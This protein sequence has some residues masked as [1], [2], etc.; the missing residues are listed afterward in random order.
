M[1]DNFISG[2]VRISDQEFKLISDL[3]YEMAG[4]RLTDQKKTLVEGRLN[5]LIRQIGC[6]SFK[7]YYDYI[8]QDKTGQSLEMMLEKISTNHSFFF[9]E[10]DHF[11]FMKQKILPDLVSKKRDLN[12][13]TLRIW[14]AGCAGGEE[15]YTIAMILL[16]YFGLE[17]REWD[18]GIVGTDISVSVL[19]IALNGCYTKEKVK[20]IPPEYKLKY[21]NPADKDYVCVKQSVKNMVMFRQLN[22]MDREFPFRGKFDIIFCRNVMIYFDRRSRKDVVDHFAEYVHNGGY[23]FIGHSESLGRENPAFRYIKP[24]V[25]LKI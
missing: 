19:G 6:D 13:K 25:Y 22:L 5:K 9:R 21:F 12:N 18:I 14:S 20:D 8:L 4:I 3:V 17:S 1:H 2:L 11:D 16:E 7:E 24:A 10:K 15:S 23:L